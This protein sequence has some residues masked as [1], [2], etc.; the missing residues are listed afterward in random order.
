VDT[1]ARELRRFENYAI[2]AGGDL[3]L[4]GHNQRGEPWTVGIR[5]PR[6]DGAIIDSVRVSDQAVCTSGDYERRAP[7][8][9]DGHHILDP[10]IGA[11][12]GVVAS[13]TAI[14]PTAMLADAVATAAF[15]LG[16]VDG[17]ALFERLQVE[18][19]ILSPA[20]E[21]FETRGWHHA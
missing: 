2:D 15:V 12:A 6:Q 4:A 10:R 20:L 19:L 13:V 17:I 14:A 18:G 5:H 7:G 8:E 3:F 16:P 9:G 21:R 11:S 1:A